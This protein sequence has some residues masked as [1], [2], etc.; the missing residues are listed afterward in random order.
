M[1]IKCEA[2]IMKSEI[3]ENV[4]KPQQGGNKMSQKREDYISWDE[5]FMGVAM[6]SGMRS[7]IRIHRWEPA[8]S[9]RI[10]RSFPWDTTDCR[11]AAPMMNFHG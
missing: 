2:E 11:R 9:V 1:I 6:L 4:K 5:Y 7:R 8:L 10:T 3:K